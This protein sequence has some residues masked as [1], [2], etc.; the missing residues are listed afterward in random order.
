MSDLKRTDKKFY[1]IVTVTLLIMLGFGCLPPFGEITPQGM[2]L[3][4]VFIGVIFAWCMGETVWSSVLA[5]V[6][7]TIFGFGTMNSNFASAYGNGNIAII[8]VACVFC[9]AVESCGL[10]KEIAKWIVGQKWAQKSPWSL[11]F[12]FY[13]AALVVGAIATNIV[14]PIVLLWALYYEVAQEIGAKPYDTFSAII[15]LGIGVVGYVGMCMVPYNIMTVIVI[16]AAEAFDTTFVLPVGSYMFLNLLIAVLFIPALIF[17]LRLLVG[18]KLGIVIV[19]K[20][21]YKIQLSKPMKWCLAY[22]LFLIICLIVPNFLPAGNWFK[23]LFGT[24]LGIVGTLMLITALMML[25]RIDDEP[26]LDIAEGIKNIPWSLVLLVSTALCISGYLTADGIGIVPT[27]VSYLNP[28]MAGKSSLVIMLLFI[29]IG[30]IMT[31]FINDVVTALVL[32]PIGAQFILDAGGSVLLLF[33]LLFAQV[34]VQGCFMPSGSIAGAMFHGNSSWM[35]S[36][37]VFKWVALM[38]AVLFVII[39]L[40]TLLAHL[41]GY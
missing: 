4:G 12:A 22:L 32:Y 41:L 24:T 23:E 38:E 3:L 29:L 35:K 18:S 10:L 28:L 16:G 27:I 7:A 5:L 11:I 30:L 21:S 26:L 9:F 14:P 25:T 6:I 15:L 33:T 13:L 36:K 8:M 40:V 31:N 34:T 39:I 19:Q 37:T 2:K 17:V 1:A 20:D